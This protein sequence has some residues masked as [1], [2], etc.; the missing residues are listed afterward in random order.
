MKTYIEKG[1]LMKPRSKLFKTITVVGI[2]IYLILV[3]VSTAASQTVIDQ[4]L[5]SPWNLGNAINECCPFVGQTYTAGATGTLAGI[6]INV[7]TAQS[8]YPLKVEIRTVAAGVPTST[9]LGEIALAPGPVPLSLLITFPQS[10]PQVAGTQYAIVVHY[11]GA[12]VHYGG[13]WG[14]VSANAYTAGEAVLSTDGLSWSRASYDLHFQTYVVTT[15]TD[16]TPPSLTVPPDLTMECNTSGGATGVALGTATATDT[17]DPSPTITNDAPGVFPLGGTIVTWTATDAS[18]NSASATQAVT[19]NDTT[20]PSITGPVDIEVI[21][22]TGGGYSG[23]ID[24]PAI[25]DVCDSA[26]VVTNDAP[27]IFPLGGTTVTWTVTDASGNEATATQVVTVKPLPVDIDVKP[28]SDPNCFNSDG[29]GVIPVAILSSAAF[30]ATQ[31]DPTTVLLDGQ[32][33]QILGKKGNVQSQT[34]DVNHDGLDDLVL[35][36]EDQDGIYEA[37]DTTAVLTGETFG[38]IPLQGEDA[39]CIRL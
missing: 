37:G 1:D 23:P 20:L 31:V 7:T 29:H 18:G 5:T 19:V 6:N 10:I 4:S 35:Q 28:G 11:P 36:I 8:T 3:F 34:E 39:I 16:T 27:S 17:V 24:T 13:S 33:V 15:T 12:P 32:A 2:N 22:N 9:V 14:G 38:D 25:S 30:D 26:P 21:A